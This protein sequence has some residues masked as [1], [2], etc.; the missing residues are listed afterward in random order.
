MN[1]DYKEIPRLYYNYGRCDNEKLKRVLDEVL[2]VVP[3][4]E[5]IIPKLRKTKKLVRNYTE[6]YYAL[7]DKSVA[8]IKKKLRTHATTWDIVTKENPETNLVPYKKFS[9]LVKSSSRFILKPDIGELIDQIDY[10]DFDDKL[11]AI[12]I[13]TD[14][15]ELPGTQGEHFIMTA[16]LLKRI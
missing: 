1:I 12:C 8:T 3:K 5:I 11:V 10:N 13:N 15:E 14:Y 9:Y 16:Q 4:I 7:D 2:F 6:K